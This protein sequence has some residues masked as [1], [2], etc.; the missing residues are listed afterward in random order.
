[1]RALVPVILGTLTLAA[2]DKSKEQA[3][4]RRAVPASAE[5][6][7]LDPGGA[8]SDPNGRIMIAGKNAASSAVESRSSSEPQAAVTNTKSPQPVEN[9]HEG[10]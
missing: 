4:E 3:G 5:N 8:M 2:C 7:V 9:S 1:M 6:R 10:H